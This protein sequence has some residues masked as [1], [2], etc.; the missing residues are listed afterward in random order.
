ME[1]VDHVGLAIS[2]L[3]IYNLDGTISI[4]EICSKIYDRYRLTLK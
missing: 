4:K 3:S 1:I 2:I